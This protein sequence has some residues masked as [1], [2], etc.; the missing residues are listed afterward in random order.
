VLL[1]CKGDE[2]QMMN[3]VGKYSFSH[4]ILE[5]T[6]VARSVASYTDDMV[7]ECLLFMN[8]AAASDRIFERKCHNINSFRPQNLTGKLLLTLPFCMQ[9]GGSEMLLN[10]RVYTTNCT[11][12]TWTVERLCLKQT[13]CSKSRKDCRK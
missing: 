6:E 12:Q 11:D 2:K 10:S 1:S 13:C 5:S 8:T 9:S 3:H 7:T 4:S